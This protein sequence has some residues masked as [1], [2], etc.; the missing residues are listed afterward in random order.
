MFNIFGMAVVE[1]AKLGKGIGAVP[2]GI[3][4]LQTSGNEKLMAVS[5]VLENIIITSCGLTHIDS[6]AIYF[7]IFIS[8]NKVM[9]AMASQQLIGCQGNLF[10]FDNMVLGQLD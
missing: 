3:M 4:I 9:V 5:C 7:Y 2:N 8:A 1:N 6:F 10:C